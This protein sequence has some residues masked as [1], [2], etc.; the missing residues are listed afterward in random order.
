MR[1]QFHN[2][3]LHSSQEMEE[4]EKIGPKIPQNAPQQ[5]WTWCQKKCID[6]QSN[7]KNICTPFHGK[8][9]NG[10]QEKEI[11]EHIPK[12]TQK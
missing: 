12:W 8:I 7:T 5:G 9:L 11:E 3:I 2:K 1:T 10:S 6:H 4:H